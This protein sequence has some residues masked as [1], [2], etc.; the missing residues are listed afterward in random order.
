MSAQLAQALRELRKWLNEEPN[1]PIDRVALARVLFSHEAS[2]QTG[3][4]S[5]ASDLR[6]ALAGCL[7]LLQ[8]HEHPLRRGAMMPEPQC[9]L[10]ARAALAAHEAAPQQEPDCWAI[11]TPNGSRLVSP[12]EAKG[13][14]DAYPLYAAP[15]QAQAPSE[16]QRRFDSLLA[17][18]HELSNSY[19]R[20]REI[21]GAMNPPVLEPAALYAYVEDCARKFVQQAQAPGW[22]LAPEKITEE[23][24]K[25]ACKVLQRANGLDGLP[26]RML[27]AIRAAAPQ[28]GSNT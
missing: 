17:A 10:D 3:Q 26:Q 4:K 19:V 22:Q 6:D 8:C 1:R 18:E 13:R 25:A 28:Q 27:D 23:Q 9:M 5:V 12:D 20:V 16:I 11:L 2:P 15:Q 21:I 7:S 14:K 24:H